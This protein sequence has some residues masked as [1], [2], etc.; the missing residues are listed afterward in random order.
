MSTDWAQEAAHRRVMRETFVPTYDPEDQRRHQDRVYQ[1]NQ[2][3]QLRDRYNQQK[4]VLAVHHKRT[5]AAVREAE[6]L[7][8]IEAEAES[9]L[10]MYG[11]E[12]AA[13]EGT[14]DADGQ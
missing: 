9:V 11:R 2:L 3:D 8:A 1:Q 7:T 5:Q 14:T 6:R 10:E 13:T 12:L 4:Q